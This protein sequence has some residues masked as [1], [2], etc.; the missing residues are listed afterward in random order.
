M[1]ANRRRASFLADLAELFTRESRIRAALVATA[2]VVMAITEIASISAIVWYLQ[3]LVTPGSSSG[4]IGVVAASFGVSIGS[5]S[6]PIAGVIVLFVLLVR[7]AV[8]IGVTWLRMDFVWSF[9]HTMSNRLMRTYLGRS[10]IEFISI[11]S[12]DLSKNLLLEVQR[13]T[14]GF[15]LP[16]IEMVSSGVLVFIVGA[17]LM[18]QSL[19]VSLAAM[20]VIGLLVVGLYMPFRKMVTKLGAE[21]ARAET[22][23]TRSAS[24][25]LS[26]F[27]DIRAYNAEGAFADRFAAASERLNHIHRHHFV[28]NEAPH[29]VMELIAFGLLVVIS[30]FAQGKSAEG[31]QVVISQLGLYAAAGYRLL[32]AV[33]RLLQSFSMA[34]F[35]Q[36]TVHELAREFR[37]PVHLSVTSETPQP[38]PFR[39]SL[40]LSDVCFSYPGSGR[41]ALEHLSFS[42]EPNEMVAI[43]GP[44]GSGKSTLVDLLIGMLEPTAGSL[45]VDDVALTRELLPNWR[46]SV[47][48]V[49]QS[50]YLVDDTIAR[51]IALGVP[52]NEIN[53]DQVRT[54]ARLACIDGVI[55]RDMPDGYF[56]TVG[57]RGV[58]FSG[59]QRQRIGLARA[60]YRQPRLLILDEGT[61]ALDSDTEH[62][63]TETLVALSASMTVVSVAHRL[64]TIQASRR[65][66]KLEHG[67]LVWDGPRERFPVTLLPPTA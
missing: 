50:I 29:Y 37:R 30:A 8:A 36:C 33:K 39:C 56:T 16:C 19:E 40:R 44:N 21:R 49:P 59:G 43:I 35:N 13:F 55:E 24:E 25:A 62:E 22:V 17:Y 64:A 46:A 18:R 61:S 58:R 11:N 23:R 38:L 34:R 48:Y 5:I 3:L 63:L 51:N 65:I 27:R 66:I 67:Q 15:L 31:G 14:S 28:V 41:P 57:E 10:Y 4:L 7:N 60:L 42:L 47:G 12:S 45:V 1:S 52:D 2:T 32:P 26:G 9:N 6:T 54:A 20:A 53:F